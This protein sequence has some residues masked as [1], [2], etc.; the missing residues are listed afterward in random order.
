[1]CNAV[2]CDKTEHSISF[3]SALAHPWNHYLHKPQ[4]HSMKIYILLIQG[5][6]LHWSE[7]IEKKKKKK[8][9]TQLFF[10]TYH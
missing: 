8:P 4:L 9:Q 2:P 5:Q 3:A 7:M 1:M 6:S 10:Q